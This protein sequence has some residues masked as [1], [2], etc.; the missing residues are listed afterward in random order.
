[1]SCHDKRLPRSKSGALMFKEFTLV[2]PLGNE[3]QTFCPATDVLVSI[4]LVKLDNF[5]SYSW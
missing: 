1:M 4:W 2:V 5:N 3:E